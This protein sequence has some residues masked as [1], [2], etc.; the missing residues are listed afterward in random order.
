MVRVRFRRSVLEFLPKYRFFFFFFT[1]IGKYKRFTGE[2][3][4]VIYFALVVGS[5]LLR[6]ET[7][8]IFR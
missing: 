5:L 2:L 4:N 8:A 1:G 6:K 3:G 7:G